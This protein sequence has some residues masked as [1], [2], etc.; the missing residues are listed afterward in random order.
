M[1]YP[2][3]GLSHGHCQHPSLILAPAYRSA[4]GVLRSKALSR[5]AN[6]CSLGHRVSVS[7]SCEWLA[8]LSLKST[9]K[10]PNCFSEKELFLSSF[11]DQ[12]AI[13]QD[14]GFVFRWKIQF[15][16]IVL[17]LQKIIKVN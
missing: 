14:H 2:Q 10:C 4:W 11:L 13:V 16:Y 3:V 12:L 1:L 9:V 17:T 6:T 7:V 8:Q 5:A 15:G